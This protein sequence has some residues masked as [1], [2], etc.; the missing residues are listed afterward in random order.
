VKPEVGLFKK[1]G[2]RQGGFTLIELMVV[3]VVLAILVAI[4][5]P[6]YEDAVRKSRRAQAKADMAE[7]AQRY[8][9]HHTIN[10][11]YV[12]FWPSVAGSQTGTVNSP[13]TQVAAP[14]YLIS[15]TANV[16]AFTLTATPQGRQTEDTR[17]GTLGLTNT[18]AKSKT[19]SG[20]LS[21]CW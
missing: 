3:M 9:R 7:L 5:Y 2:S 13:S 18:G 17:C 15:S 19:G 14:A 21:D 6:S 4:A 10:N 12:G 1:A 11:T 20:D 16:N 8:E